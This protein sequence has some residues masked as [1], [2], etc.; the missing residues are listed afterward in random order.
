V[1]KINLS[2]FETV[3]EFVFEADSSEISFDEGIEIIGKMRV[4]LELTKE[5]A[6]S[7]LVKGRLEGDIRQKCSRCLSDFESPVTTGFA[8]MFRD[9]ALISDEDRQSDYYSYSNN[10]IDLYPYLRE[11]LILEAPVKPV[12]SDECMGLC[13]V[14][15]KNRNIEKCSCEI[16]ETYRPFEN[17]DL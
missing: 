13:P 12:C 5:G 6:S 11:T 4:E 10:E 3:K 8:V 1:F 7:V 9:A 16:K 14:C 15:G 2:S 17:L